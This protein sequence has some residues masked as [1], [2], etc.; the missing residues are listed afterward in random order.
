MRLIKYNKQFKNGKSLLLNVFYSN[1]FKLKPFKPKVSIYIETQKYIIKS[2]ENNGELNEALA[3][4]Y[5]IFSKEILGKK[6]F[7]K[8]DI[9]K[10]DKYCDHII[11]IDKNIN[12]I[13]GTY[14][15]N[16]YNKKFYSAKE[17][18]IN[19]LLA[20]KGKKAELG[21]ACILKNYRKG[22]VLGLLWKGIQCYIKKEDIQYLFG[23]SSIFSENKQ[24]AISVFDFFKINDCLHPTLLVKPKKKYSFKQLNLLNSAYNSNAM[25]IEPNIIP[26]LLKSYLKFGAKIC[27]YPAYDKEFRCFDFLT[28]IDYNTVN[29]EK[30]DIIARL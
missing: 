6:N 8:I 17:F 18:Y 29:T 28:V 25:D 13:I 11:I 14:R 27:S 3:L 15:I 20:L 7:F 2:A 30:K 4:R 9:D 21:R 1:Y 16:I 26:D 23:C 12:K 24:L 22:V 10:F 5:K 19:D